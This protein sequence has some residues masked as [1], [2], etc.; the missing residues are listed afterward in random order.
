MGTKI[1]GYFEFME[2]VILAFPSLITPQQ[3]GAIR[4]RGK[5]DPKFDATFLISPDSAEYA[6]A[7]DLIGTVAKAYFGEHLPAKFH[8]PVRLGDADADKAKAAGKNHEA[9]RGYILLT[10]RTGAD[11]PPGLA[12]LLDDGSVK[13]FALSG[14]ARQ[15]ARPYFRGGMK[16]VFAV[17]FAAYESTAEDG[18]PGVTAYLQMVASHGGV[19]NAALEANGRD[20]SRLLQPSSTGGVQTNVT[21]LAGLI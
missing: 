14:D 5:G 13:S 7:R 11:K 21:P 18:T 1:N 16:V 12:A 17:N 2:P 10:A 15:D 19:P 9:Y 6:K 4:G 3:F 8:W 20:A